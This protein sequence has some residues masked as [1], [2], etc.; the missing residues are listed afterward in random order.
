MF[1]LYIADQ[2][3]GFAN[4]GA[5]QLA[6]LH[7][8]GH[9]GLGAS[10]KKIQQIVD[11]TAAYFA[12]RD[13]GLEDVGVADLSDAPDCAL[14][15]QAVD[16]GLDARVRRAIRLRERLLNLA[17]RQPS[18]FPEFFHDLKFSLR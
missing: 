5:R 18:V 10:A 2:L 1:S 3:F 15:F 6:G 7:Q 12:P 9:H 16:D 14:L 4:V 13:Y 11:E 17:N 8:M